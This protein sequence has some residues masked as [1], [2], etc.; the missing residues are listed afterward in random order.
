MIEAITSFVSDVY[1]AL[2]EQFWHVVAYP[3]MSG[4][5]IYWLYILTSVIIAFLVYV[6]RAK[7]SEEPRW[8]VRGFISFLFPKKVWGTSSA[9]LDVRYFFFHQILGK[10]VYGII[11]AV[12][13][14]GLFQWTTG[15][16]NLIEVA[17][18]GPD[19]TWTSI[20][21]SFGYMFAVIAVVDF[22]GFFLHFLQHKVPILWEFH[23]VHHSAEV[24]HPL[25]NYREHPIDN[26]TY[27]VGIGA[28]F[29]LM[30]GLA[31]NFFGYLPSMPEVI[32]VPL[33][34]FLFNVVGYNLRHSHIWLRWPGV[35]SMIFPSPAHHHVHHSCHP[36]HLDRN[37]A[38]VLPLW[39]VLFRTYHMPDDD[40]DIEF[41]LYG[42]DS[43]EYSSCWR[44]YYIPFRNIFAKALSKPIADTDETAS[45]DSA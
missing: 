22:M 1:N 19:V 43:S 31:Q 44:L 4:Q 23:K 38:F 25:S 27:A 30:M 16:P 32:G 8:G 39:D 34:L 33:I 37:F 24:M 40:R 26:F 5:R 28:A 42:Q 9:W 7:S 36:D 3:I 18:S 41:G 35:L 29:G 11:I 14:N 6:R 2:Y 13:M 12:T 20:L 17:R 45:R 10:L 21:V 15:G